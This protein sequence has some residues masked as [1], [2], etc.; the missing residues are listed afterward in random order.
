[1]KKTFFKLIIIYMAAACCFVINGCSKSKLDLL[2]H[3]PTEQSYFTKEDD[4]TKAV[5]GVYAKM[6][7]FFWY[8]AGSSPIP[9]FLLPGD[10]ITTNDNNEPFETF[11][12]LQPS[13]G[14]LSTLYAAHY[15]MIARAN[16]VLDKIAG[17]AS[18]IYQ[19]ANLENYHKG[20]VLFLRGYAF[21][22]LWNFF[23]TSPLVLERVTNDNQFTP[24]GTTGT[25]LLDQAIQDFTDAA[26][27]LPAS[28]DAANRGRV[29][30]NS[31]NG[32]LGK[33]LVF[34]A[35]VTGGNAA[36]YTA[37]IAAFN[38][39]SGAQLQTDFGDNF[40]FDTENNSE[41]LFEFQASQAFGFDN[42]WL[43]NDFD[44]AVGALSIFWGFYDNNFALFGRSRFYVTPK[45]VST[46][47][48]NDPRLS[49]TLN[50]SDSTV[51]KYVKRDKKSQSGVASVNN[52]RILRFADV[53]LLKAEAVLQSGG[54]TS[55]AIGYINLVRARARVMAPAGTE[56]ADRS[57]AE[58]DKTKIMQWIMDERLI[59][60]AG[61]GQRWFDMR[62]WQ[63]Q[64]ILTVDNSTFSSNVSA[65]MN[66]QVAKHLYFPIPN[67]EIDVNP[68]VKQNPGY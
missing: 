59:E 28:W 3:G 52:Y 61:E 6:T 37:A 24:P 30:A 7:D 54:S 63:I 19:T 62:R 35:S 60:L 14:T 15:Q 42:V 55:E 21:Y 33:S 32:M 64:G 27:L 18:G 44:N 34:R 50:P 13:D 2:P 20:E 47:D 58:T 9:A 23:G 8:N 41:S 10:D 57:A 36:D 12:S 67:S 49:L 65:N 5:L 45:L 43:S 17:V 53:L 4:F 39:V 25:Q 46:F 31:A 48:A 51:T 66:F 38:K 22:N 1:M 56:P 16:L 68:N 26:G 40:A 29:T 11:G